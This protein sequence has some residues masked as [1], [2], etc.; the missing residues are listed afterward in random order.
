MS[1]HS[2]ERNAQKEINMKFDSNYRGSQRSDYEQFTKFLSGKHRERET[3]NR[4]SDNSVCESHTCNGRPIAMVYCE[5]QD[6]RKLYDVEIGLSNGTIFEELD[7]P[8]L[9]TGCMGGQKGCRG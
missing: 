9:K 6:W 1:Y 3:E 2:I 8:L 5:W 4:L 7:L